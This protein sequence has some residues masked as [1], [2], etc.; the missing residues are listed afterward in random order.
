[1]IAVSG[2]L[3]FIGYQLMVYGWSQIHGGNAG[4]FDLLWPGRYT[5]L[6]PD[7]GS[8][9][10]PGTA[11]AGQGTANALQVGVNKGLISQ[12]TAQQDV[13]GNATVGLGAGTFRAFNNAPTQGG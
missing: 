12:Q 2:G 9:T 1:M 6:H 10:A 5:G 7:S 4:F 3:I 8:A 11:Q 13:S